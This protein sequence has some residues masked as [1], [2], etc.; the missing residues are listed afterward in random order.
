MSERK[1]RQYR[2]QG[3]QKRLRRFK[4]ANRVTAEQ[5]NEAREAILAD[6]AEAQ[7]YYEETVAALTEEPQ[8][9]ILNPFSG[10]TLVVAAQSMIFPLGVN[11]RGEPLDGDENVGGQTPAASTDN[12]PVDDG[13]GAAPDAPGHD[14]GCTAENP[15]CT[16]EG[17]Y[18]PKYTEADTQPAQ[19]KVI[20][21]GT[22]AALGIETP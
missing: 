14:P 16:D 6:A 2:S 5:H 18:V 7:K 3:G 1:A 21:P 19:T 9:A 22:A 11:G 15:C 10:E 12:D 20:L 17:P 4:K 13:S 8:F